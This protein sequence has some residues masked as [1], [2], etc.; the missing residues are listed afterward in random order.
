MPVQRKSGSFIKESA[1]RNKKHYKKEEIAIKELIKNS[2]EK[3]YHASPHGFWYFYN[4]RDTSTVASTPTVG[5]RVHFTYNIKTLKGQEIL[6]KTETGP[7]QYTIDQSNQ[8]LIS[9]LRDGLKLMKA[10]EQ[11]T[12][13]FPS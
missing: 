1:Q 6:S 7:Q 3:T 9:G 13:L 4:V 11:V 2:P 5:D 10:G 8:E 12:F